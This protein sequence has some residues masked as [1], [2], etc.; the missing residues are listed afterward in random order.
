MARGQGQDSSS[1]RAKP[2]AREH[3]RAG[4]GQR[5]GHLQ[6]QGPG[7]PES[8]DPEKVELPYLDHCGKNGELVGGG[9]NWSSETTTKGRQW[10][11]VTI[12]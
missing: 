1:P 10:V 8:R 3:K 4:L 6:P 2:A 7:V 11:D 5:T 9:G 12:G